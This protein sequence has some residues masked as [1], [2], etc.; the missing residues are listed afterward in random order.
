ML[1]KTYLAERASMISME[2]DMGSATPGVP[3]DAFDF[4][5]PQMVTN[6][7][8]TSHISIIDS[9]GN[10]IS[11]TTTVESYFGSG[12]ML[13]E[14]GF[15]LNNQVTDFSFSPTDGD[16][17]P[18]ANRVQPSKRP[19][20]S[21]SP[22]IVM[23]DGKPTYLAGSPG[24]FRIIGYTSKALMLMLDY[25]YDP[26]AAANSPHSQ[27][28]NGDTELEP[29][30]ENITSEYDEATLTSQLEGLGHVVVERGGE[31]SGLSLI[32][33]SS[34]GTL[35]GGADPR[36]DGT[37]G[38]RSSVDETLAPTAASPTSSSDTEA[39]NAAPSPA[40][41]AASFTDMNTNVITIVSL[42][43]SLVSFFPLS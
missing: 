25:G 26:Q 30:M 35:S 34:D 31:T 38:G 40:P 28:Q 3:P 5:S 32:A 43:T 12:L 16:G 39:P 20:S 27:N 42:V 23:K 18:I 22:T 37:A 4:S 29:V 24:G 8:G 7:G 33:I 9:M 6:E 17:V 41:S 36:R 13:E 14:W 19:R 10:A 2:Q 11:M 1:N 21:M 15:L